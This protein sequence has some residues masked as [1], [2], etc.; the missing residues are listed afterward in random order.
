LTGLTTSHTC[1]LAAATP[2][3]LR[4]LIA[5]NLNALDAILQHNVK[6]GWLL[7]R[8]GSGVIPFGSHPV[9]QL[10][11]WREYAPEL[12]ALGD[13][14]R[15]H[16]LR[17]SIHPGQY[18]VLSSPDEKIRAAARAELTYAARVL[19][20]LGVDHTNKIVLHVGG[21]YGDKAA[22][23]ERFNV[24]ISQLP[25]S[26]HQRLV[27]ENDERTYSAEEVLAIAQ[28]NGVPMVFDNLH[29]AANPGTVPLQELLP[30]IFSTWRTPDGNAKVHFSSQAPGAR[31]GKHAEFA[32]A[33]EFCRWVRL[34][35]HAGEFD[36]MLEAKGKDRALE[37]LLKEANEL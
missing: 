2:E 36:V 17:L 19:D 27:L 12:R 16:Q 33:G 4:A 15:A 8:I 20:S 1:R 13:Y 31:M 22:A 6:N 34:W 32:D 18:T 11:W 26:V 35:G 28:Q 10:E 37:K 14:A 25:S 29:H 24:E 30:Q 23:I 5:Q 3:R 7:F 21:A 9:N